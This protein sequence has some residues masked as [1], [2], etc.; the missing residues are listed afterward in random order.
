MALLLL[1]VLVPAQAAYF[2]TNYSGTVT[3]AA[4]GEPLP[5]V[6]VLNTTTGKGT[7]TNVDGKF[8]L[9][10]E[11]GQTIRIS[12]IGYA[13]EE[14]VL[15]QNT[16]LNVA[17][18]EQVS[19][20]ESVVVVG[21]RGRPRTII[22]SPVPIDNINAAALVSSGQ[23]T[24]EQMI[25]YRVPSFNS[26]NQTISDATA[27]FDPSELR[28]LGPSRTLVLVNGKRKNQSALVYVNDTPG[29]GEVGTDMKSI[30]TSAIERVEVLRDGAAAQY[31]SD[32]IAGVIN[33]V[34]KERVT[35]SANLNTGIT[36][37][38]DG[39]M[40][41]A[42]V[43][44]G[45]R[46]GDN[47]V[48][49]ITGNFYHQDHTDR[50]G[51]PGGDG[52]FGVI[53]QPDPNAVANGD[54]TQAEYDAALAF[55]NSILNGT[56]PWIQ[57][58][59]D[60]GMTV[61]QPEYDKAS[62]YLNYVNPY[63]GGQGEIYAFGGYTWRDGR[64]FALYRTP[65]WITDDAGLLTPAGET[66]SGFQ[67]TFDTKIIDYTATVG[68]RYRLGEWNTDLSVTTGSNSVAYTIENTIN[69]ALLPNSP[70][71]FDAGAYRFGTILGNLDITRSWATVEL[72]LGTEVRR[73]S[74]DVVA[75]QEE[76]YIDG[77]AQ[78]F[79]GLQP[80]NALT[81][82]RNNVGVYAGLDWDATQTLLLGVPCG[83]KTIL[84]LAPTCRGNS[85]LARCLPKAVAP[86]ALR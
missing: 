15:G 56:D 26:T 23:S 34:L 42:S 13:S 59:P 55:A 38:G 9:A 76:S 20:L 44:K 2:Q 45:F 64:S 32:A 71:V 8:T 78:S 46:I 85:M 24:I 47:G 3:D 57:E 7:S 40:Y 86:C 37:M 5:G 65:Y 80:G 67:P 25:N 22:E 58:N 43:N 73:E 29:K 61:G 74:F 69:P 62:G 18:G 49:N 50:S 53:F 84:T 66:Y 77:G 75:G 41:E 33:I 6:T 16:T 83:S 68:N 4:T 60:L 72:S 14:I 36:T 31:G 82:T 10:G 48:L 51:V 19:V 79:P 35:G 28:N 81:A 12:Y 11:A 27:H 54:M 63:A 1:T 52:L 21:S 70:T 30:P 39:F 17:L